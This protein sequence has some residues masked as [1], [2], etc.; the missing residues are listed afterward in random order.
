MVCHSERQHF[1]TDFDIRI[2][3]LRHDPVTR[4]IGLSL[5]SGVAVTIAGSL[6]AQGKLDWGLTFT[7]GIVASLLGDIE[8][9]VVGRTFGAS[10]LAKWGPFLGLSLARQTFFASVLSR[11]GASTVFLSRTL[12]ATLSTV[13]SL[14]AG[15]SRYSATRF[16]MLSLVGRSF[17]TFAYLWLGYTI[18]TEAEA[19]ASFLRNLSGLLFSLLVLSASFAILIKGTASR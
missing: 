10:L 13:V 3:G 2:R 18:G 7:L 11:W 16:A 19:A 14:L 1:V 4:C 17:W 12:I 8:G 15:V 5:P 6:P 9:Y